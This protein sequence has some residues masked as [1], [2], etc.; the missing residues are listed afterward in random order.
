M[1]WAA[2]GLYQ[3]ILESL[4]ANAHHRYV[5]NIMSSDSRTCGPGARAFIRELTGHYGNACADTAT[6][7]PATHC[8]HVWSILYDM[9]ALCGGDTHAVRVLA[10]ALAG[11][12]PIARERVCLHAA[13]SRTVLSDVMQAGC[14]CATS[15]GK[16][17]VAVVPLLRFQENDSTETDVRRGRR[18]RATDV[19]TCGDGNLCGLS[20]VGL[21]VWAIVATVCVL[22]ACACI[23]VLVKD[24]KTPK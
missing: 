3:Q 7:E 19:G 12:S 21:L 9:L 24:R 17:C 15:G 6:N 23:G 2:I 1:L 11:L 13:S 22:A 8:S 4:R 5:S 16:S 18:L 14:A 10:D 20:R